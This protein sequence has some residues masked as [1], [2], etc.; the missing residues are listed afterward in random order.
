MYRPR[1][2]SIGTRVCEEPCPREVEMPL[3]KRHWRRRRGRVSPARRQARAGSG[4]HSQ[5]PDQSDGLSSRRLSTRCTSSNIGNVRDIRLWSARS[6][7]APTM[8]E[9]IDQQRRVEISSRGVVTSDQ[10]SQS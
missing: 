5:E 1:V 9:L 3:S 8:A 6:T 7:G 10:L 2:T 4:V